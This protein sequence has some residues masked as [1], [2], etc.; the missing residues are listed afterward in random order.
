MNSP[1]LLEAKAKKE[2]RKSG[3]LRRGTKIFVEEDGTYRTFALRVFLANLLI[4]RV[5]VE[6]TASGE[7][8]VHY[9]AETLDDVAAELFENVC[10]G[11]V[12]EHID[13]IKDRVAPFAGIS[14]DEVFAYAKHFGWKGE[15]IQKTDDIRAFLT[16]FTAGHPATPHA[17]KNVRDSLK[18]LELNHD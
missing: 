18:S 4:K 11:T 3:G 17:L 9:S 1:A 2:I 6:F 13:S 5:D 16:R 8:A 15:H 14:D 7:D 10:T 12:I